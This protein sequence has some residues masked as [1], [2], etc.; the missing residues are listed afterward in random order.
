MR[1]RSSASG[2]TRV[3]VPF[4]G[5]APSSSLPR[6]AS[7]DT[8]HACLCVSHSF[9]R[10]LPNAR[11]VESRHIRAGVDDGTPG[12][13]RKHWIDEAERAL[14][15]KA[16]ERNA[17]QP[18]AQHHEH[19]RERA[20]KEGGA[21]TA[22][23]KRCIDLGDG[24]LIAWP[25]DRLGNE[26]P[27]G[28]LDGKMPGVA[29]QRSDGTKANDKG[30]AGE[31]ARAGE[32][33]APAGG[34]RQGAGRRQGAA[35]GVSWRSL[36]LYAQWEAA[37]QSQLQA[38]AADC[39]RLSADQEQDEG[40]Q[41]AHIREIRQQVEALRAEEG[42]SRKD[43]LGWQREFEQQAL[44]TQALLE[45]VRETHAEVMATHDTATAY[46]HEAAGAVRQMQHQRVANEVLNL[47]NLPWE[48]TAS[49]SCPQRPHATLR[50]MPC[51]HAT[52][53]CH[54]VW[55]ASVV[56]HATRVPETRACMVA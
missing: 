18:R 50:S 13:N 17:V 43:V 22:S 35:R 19:E 10:S 25:N 30:D 46:C 37:E 56:L 47:L 9:E 14:F 51:P 11:I 28:P 2:G 52:P 49:H 32:S 48:L 36:R 23:F 55:H 33:F 15:S 20:K 5:C 34:G 26:Y 45:S 42:V 16:E 7:R 53:A 12:A 54:G 24:V 27:K 6:S 21:A 44:V 3:C 29:D 8:R 38:A 31:R 40:V 39:E 4:A 41:L 1:C